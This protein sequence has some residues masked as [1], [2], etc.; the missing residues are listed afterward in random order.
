MNVLELCDPEAAAVPVEASVAEAIQKMLD[1]HVGA[2]GRYAG[3]GLGI[4]LYLLTARLVAAALAAYAKPRARAT[5]IVLIAL[6]SA[7]LL[8]GATDPLQ[9]ALERGD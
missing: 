9:M 1:F 4:A 6:C 5:R 7:L 8:A 2:P 3:I